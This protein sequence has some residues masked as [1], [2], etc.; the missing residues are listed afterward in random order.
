MEATSTTAI[1]PAPANP[2][3]ALGDRAH[4]Y[5]QQ[6][7]APNTRRAYAADWRTFTAWCAQHQLAALPATPETVALYLV[8]HAGVRKASTLQRALVAIAHAHRAADLE[9]PTT[10]VVVRTT[11]RGIRRAHGTA[12]QGKAPTVVPMLRAMVSTCGG[13][14]RGQ[15]DRAL[16]LLGFAGAFRRSELVA[17][18][19]ADVDFTPSGL[20]VQLQ[21]SKTDQEGEGRRV[22]IPPGQHEPTC[23]LR[24]LG[25]WLAAAQ[26]EDGPLFRP[27]DR[28][29]HVGAARLSDKAVAR[30]VKA[31]ATAAGYDAAAYAGHSL[32]AGLATS[33]AAAGVEER[34]VAQQTGHRS[35][36]V[37]R[38]YI[39]EGE[40]FRANA[41]AAV[42]L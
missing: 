38:R 16:L 18:D 2:L 22:G 29:G 3:A 5:L 20:V 32:R 24:A 9:P 39:R 6:A 31:H 12:Q 40:L 42:G 41:A 26:L 27:V 36:T 15:R 7:T 35:M 21:R 25:D 30:I 28:G 19:V 37:L 10:H 23:P 1:T 4:D 17:L 14:L 11:W 8:D 13:D 34:V 33:A